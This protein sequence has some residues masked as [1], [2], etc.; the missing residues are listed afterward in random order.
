MPA[1]L[2]DWSMALRL[3]EISVH[4][5]AEKRRHKRMRELQNHC[6][7]LSR[8]QDPAQNHTGQNGKLHGKRDVRH[9]SRFQEKAW[10][11][12]SNSQPQVDYGKTERIQPRCI[13][14]LH[15]LQQGL[16]LYRS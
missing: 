2:E 16:R 4:S 15:R 14:L 8:Q 6:S 10:D 12:R 3:E 7:D 1:G 9:S 5:D 13:P 11:T